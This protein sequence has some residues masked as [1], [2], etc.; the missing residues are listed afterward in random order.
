M[1]Q[2]RVLSPLFA[3]RERQAQRSIGACLPAGAGLIS[4]GLEGRVAGL[5]A[6]STSSTAASLHPT[7]I[8]AP[9][10]R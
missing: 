9:A 10:E 3:R 2:V 5:R 7:P 1:S 4:V 6:R 8:T